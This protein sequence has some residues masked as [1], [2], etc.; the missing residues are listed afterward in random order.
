MKILHAA[1]LHRIHQA[2]LI[3]DR[4]SVKRKK[5]ICI[6]GVSLS[7]AH[8]SSRRAKHTDRD[9]KSRF[10]SLSKETRTAI[11]VVKSLNVITHFLWDSR[12]KEKFS[13]LGM[14]CSPEC[15]KISK[16]QWSL[17]ARKRHSSNYFIFGSFLVAVYLDCTQ[18]PRLWV[19]WSERTCEKKQAPSLVIE[20]KGAAYSS[21]CR[22][23]ILVCFVQCCIPG[24]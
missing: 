11:W 13:E 17:T 15:F 12:M 23:G 22:S 18:M 9:L 5:Y 14:K 1:T 3:I 19:E 16:Q 10:S 20:E 2:I 4:N 8:F 7:H 21:I 24:V 6:S